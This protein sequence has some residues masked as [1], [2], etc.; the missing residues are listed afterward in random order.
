MLAG[1]VELDKVRLLPRGEIGLPRNHPLARATA[2][3]S[4]FRNQ[5]V[6][7]FG[8]GAEG[9]EKHPADGGRGVDALVEHHQVHTGG[10]QA[11]GQL[12]QMFQRPAQPVQLGHHQL[13]A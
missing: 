3:P 1:A 7:E 6:L 12:D 8:N 2:M 9:L 4:R 13:I 11:L 5:G 10:L